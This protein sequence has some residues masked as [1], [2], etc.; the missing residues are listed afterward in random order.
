MPSLERLHQLSKGLSEIWPPHFAPEII[1]P[2]L[3]GCYE[4]QAFHALKTFEKDYII[5]IKPRV[6]LLT[7]QSRVINV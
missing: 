2:I 5:A 7:A 1:F 6:L 3:S 4:G